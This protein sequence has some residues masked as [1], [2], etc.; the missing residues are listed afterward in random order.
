MKYST[1]SSSLKRRQFLAS[2]VASASLAA[3]PALSAD[4][5]DGSET[6]RAD[7]R[8]DYASTGVKLLTDS[9]P[10]ADG[11]YMPGEEKKHEATVMVFP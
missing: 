8:P 11:F 9:T 2:G 10:L 1:F 5:D 6:E 4:A 7:W 3:F